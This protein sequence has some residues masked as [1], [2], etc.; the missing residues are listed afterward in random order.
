M[1][2]DEIRT[3]AQTRRKTAMAARAALSKLGGAVLILPVDVSKAEAPDEP[4][5]AVHVA[6]TH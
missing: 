6:H 5:F 3:P 1:F 2:C 4:P